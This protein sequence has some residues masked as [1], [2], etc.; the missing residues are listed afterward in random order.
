MNEY[1]LFDAFGGID[2]E[3][4]ERSEHKTARKLPVRKVLIAAAA[5]MMM[6]VTV[7][8]SPSIRALL[9]PSEPVMTSEG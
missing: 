4:L 7:F 6:V 9:F 5:V 2:E 8:A 3:L 1:D